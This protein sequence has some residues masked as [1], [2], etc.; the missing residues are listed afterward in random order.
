M[1]ICL[2]RFALGPARF[3]VNGRRTAI[4]FRD[5][6]SEG[7]NRCACHSGGRGA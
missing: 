7:P 6:L 3:L 4:A 2:E 1:R 5:A